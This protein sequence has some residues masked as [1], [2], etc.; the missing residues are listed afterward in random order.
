MES[1]GIRRSLRVVRAIGATHGGGPHRQSIRE[2]ITDIEIC[3]SSSALSA[4]QH[5]IFS[6]LTEGMNNNQQQNCQAPTDS[7]LPHNQ[8]A[9]H[10]QAAIW[11]L[12]ET[13]P[14]DSQEGRSE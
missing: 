12:L 11:Y 8:R 1:R 6:L 13:L 14:L 10:A 9:V 4:R 5:E 3:M 7:G 2:A